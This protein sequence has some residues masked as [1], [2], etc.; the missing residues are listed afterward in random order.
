MFTDTTP[1][2][3]ALVTDVTGKVYVWEST[4]VPGTITPFEGSNV[5]TWQTNGKGWFGAGIMSIQPVNLFN[6]PDGHLKFRIKIPANVTFK[7]GI[8]DS[9]NNQYYVSFPA[10]QTKYGLT[11][12]G[13]WGQASIPVA[14]LRGTAIDLRMMSYEFVILEEQGTGCEFAIDDVYWDGG[15]LTAVDG[16]VARE[17]ASAIVPNPFNGRT[18]IRYEVRT[19]GR[20]RITAVDVAGRTVARLLDVR[21]VADQQ[22][23]GLLVPVD[24][25]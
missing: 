14:D 13:E 23:D 12:N 2:N 21:H 15:A 11:R 4:L 20:V 5:L 1:T 3:D 17:L 16:P 8:I 22:A 24:V 7:I 25:A 10:G 18:S 19:P 9:W 6:F